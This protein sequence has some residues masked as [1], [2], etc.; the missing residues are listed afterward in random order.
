LRALDLNQRPLVT[1]GFLGPGWGWLAEVHGQFTDEIDR[2]MRSCRLATAPD[3]VGRQGW[4]FVLAA[5]M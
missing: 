5:M 1:D 2:P 4:L 3:R